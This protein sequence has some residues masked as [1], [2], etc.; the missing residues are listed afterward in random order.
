M[1]TNYGGERKEDP[2]M[3][4]MGA[5]GKEKTFFLGISVF[6][7]F[8]YSSICVNLSN[9]WMERISHEWTRMY[10]KGVQPPAI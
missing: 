6:S 3:S 2:Q 8:H 1:D 5:D 10:A 7:S 9:L 4:Q